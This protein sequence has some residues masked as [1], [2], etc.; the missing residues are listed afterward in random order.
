MQADQMG[1][2]PLG[3]RDGDSDPPG[4]RP[5]DVAMHQY[6]LVGHGL[7][8]GPGGPYNVETAGKL[9]NSPLLSGLQRAMLGS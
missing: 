5:A 4:G 9:R 3:Q 8:P 7:L 2:E 6:R 1:V